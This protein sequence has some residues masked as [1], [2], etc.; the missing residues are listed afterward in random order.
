[1]PACFGN[2]AY[3]EFV[4]LSLYRVAN[5]G[6]V[7]SPYDAIAMTL[8]TLA[9]ITAHTAGSDRLEVALLAQVES[10][11]RIGRKNIVVVLDTFPTLD[12]SVIAALQRLQR[13]TS[14]L[15]GECTCVALD[16]R[17]FDTFRSLPIAQ[18]M[19]VI[20]RVDQIPTHAA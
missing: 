2:K 4:L 20:R 7:A 13:R 9:F 19:R 14:E 18:T 11:A 17:V 16:E 15:G 3:G 6:I 10:F 1:M 12:K 5:L 8:R